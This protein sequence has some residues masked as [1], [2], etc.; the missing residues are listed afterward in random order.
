MSVVSWTEIAGK[1]G[2]IDAMNYRNYTRE[3]QVITNNPQ[4]GPQTVAAAI[5]RRFGHRTTAPPRSP[6]PTP[7]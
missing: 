2:G 6:T 1:N 4:D 7:N 5:P 3:F